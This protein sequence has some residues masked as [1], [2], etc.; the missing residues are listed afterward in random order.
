MMTTSASSNMPSS[1]PDMIEGIGAIIDR[2]D[3]FILDIFGVIHDGIEPFE[4]TIRCLEELQ[5]A[6]KGVCLLS[7]SPRRAH[8]AGK[9][10]EFMGI[11][12]NLYDHIITSGEATYNYLQNPENRTGDK[13][14]YIGTDHD[15]NAIADLD[16]QQV[17]RLEDADFILNSIPGTTATERAKLIDDL[18]LA[19]EHNI[20]MVCA[21][22]DL[23]V[24]IG[25]E[26]YECAG[27]FA[28]IYEQMGGSVIYF[29]KPHA[30]VYEECHAF[31]NHGDKSRIVAVGDSLHT[32]VSGASRFGI[33]SCFNIE[34][35]HR[36]ELMMD[37]AHNISD[38]QK[39]VELVEKQEHK[40]THVMEGFQW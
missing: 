15:Y 1:A 13:Y 10:M 6:A 35:I 40:P 11:A 25:D 4:G 21:N 32:D 39:I 36:E 7:N 37:R 34:G 29:G 5:K 23:V 30:P 17:G 18:Q 38:P 22:P 27:S 8:S 19:Q 3:Y 12:P 24:N 2:Y 16:L 28:R 26:Q 9:Q 33:A 20:P 14:W 31:F